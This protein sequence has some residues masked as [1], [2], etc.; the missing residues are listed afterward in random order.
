MNHEEFLNSLQ[1]CKNVYHKFTSALDVAHNLLIYFSST[2]SVAN[3]VQ[4]LDHIVEKVWKEY[5]CVDFQT[6]N[7]KLEY[8]NCCP[9]NLIARSF[10]K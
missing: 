8:S 9:N 4:I 2:L 10:T 7:V 1:Y 3:K 5:H 6:R